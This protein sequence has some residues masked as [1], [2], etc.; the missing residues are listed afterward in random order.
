MLRAASLTEKGL[1]VQSDKRSK[2]SRFLGC[3]LSCNSAEPPVQLS[4]GCS[5]IGE[6]ITP[7]GG[8]EEEPGSILT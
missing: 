2:L 7:G 6:I 5:L 1:C 8:G 3:V 4:L